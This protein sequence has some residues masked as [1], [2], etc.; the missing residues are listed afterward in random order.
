MLAGNKGP[1]Q[2]LEMC[3]GARC[4]AVQYKKQLHCLLDAEVGGKD[5]MN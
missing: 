1:F 3:G 4:G 2:S 5:C